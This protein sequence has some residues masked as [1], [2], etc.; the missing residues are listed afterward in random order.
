MELLKR[1]NNYQ[2]RFEFI[3]SMVRNV[4]LRGNAYI[5]DEDKVN[6]HLLKPDNEDTKIIWKNRDR[7]Y[8]TNLPTRI[9]G[10]PMPVVRTLTMDEVTHIKGPS[11]DNLY[12][13]DNLLL[14]A[15]TFEVHISAVQ[16]GLD[17][18]NNSGRPSGIVNIKDSSLT[19]QQINALADA[20]RKNNALGKGRS[21]TVFLKG[22]DNMQYTTIGTS[23]TEG[24]FIPSQEHII[25]EVARI[26]N[27]SPTKLHDLSRASYNNITQESLDFIEDTIKPLV[28]RVEAGLSELVPRNNRVVI[29]TNV[30]TSETRLDRYKAYLIGVKGGWLS[31]EQVAEIEGIPIE[32][33][34]KDVEQEQ[35]NYLTNN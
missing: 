30:L 15:N 12:G 20:W 25:R 3:E 8:K 26:L 7:Y 29:D 19:A 33:V 2:N 34:K 1:P 18:F 27:I 9:T 22:V 17:F 32:E 23:P 13:Y 31:P 4:V 35:D 14:F 11:D 5:Y 24:Q 21:S 28:A 10:N 6:L 16:M